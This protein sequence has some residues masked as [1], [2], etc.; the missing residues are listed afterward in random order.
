MTSS[1]LS[2]LKALLLDADIRREDAELESLL[3][4]A[5]AAPDDARDRWT[6][7]LAPSADP[8]LRDRLVSAG[9]RFMDGLGDS[10]TDGPAPAS[11]LEALRDEMRRQGLDGLVIPRTDEYQ[12]EYIPQKSER[13]LWLTG[14]SGSAGTVVVGLDKAAIFVDG[15]YT[16]Q[17]RDQVN[18]DL[19]EPRH[20]IEQP[21]TEW[22]A[23][24]FKTGDRIGFD[25]WLHT[26]HGAGH[27][28]IAAQKAGATLIRVESNPV[29]VVWTDRPAAP[30]APVVPQEMRFAGESGEDKRARLGKALADK[31]IDAAAI[32][33]TDSIAWLLNMRG[34]DVPNCPLPLSFALLNA[35]A[36]VDWFIDD[37]KLT[38]DARAALGNGIAVRPESEF[39]DALADLG[40]QGKTV[41]ADPA[42]APCLVF[43]RLSQY[44]AKTV[45]AADPC[46]LPKACKNDV[47]IDGTRVA[48]KRD[49]AALSRFLH[50]LSVEAPKGGQT[51]LSVIDRLAQFRA[52]GEHF[53][54]FSFD[55]IA[56][57][58]PNGAVI[59]YRA[60]ER[61]NRKVETGQLLLVDSGG[62]YLDGTTDVT[63][64]MAVGTPTR[65][66]MERF[67]LVLKGHIAIATARF[68][69]GVTGSQ[70]DTLAR[71]PLWQ[72]GLDFDHGTGHGVGSYLN[73]HE[74]PQRIAKA[75][76]A[77]ALKPG[78]ILSNEPGYY[79]AGEYGIRIENL[80][81]VRAV[82]TA[83]DGAE[84]DLLEFETITLAPI[85][86]TLIAVD[87]LTGSERDWLN[88][89]HA[90]VRDAVLPQL[91]GEAADWL[92][93][94]TEPV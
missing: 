61:T 76:N 71:L 40:R 39:A 7:L 30:V 11:R 94:A 44:G 20:L 79:K 92:R 69:V 29:D 24:N 27:L 8:G 32:T 3:R 12:G 78:M 34:A 22:I 55:T 73:V 36:T 85:D 42:T 89:Y 43:D 83:P 45:E 88:V 50:W 28:N 82:E 87:M 18:V 15:R 56:G 4:G 66:M 21:A 58:G 14:F 65:E 41:Q 47:E 17:V 35:D 19:F 46:L 59:H 67:T 91:D 33:A 37:R 80:V 2:D 52:E 23:E 13:V 53:R 48:H 84:K 6:E 86:R 1:A 81:V 77:V 75:F 74:G 93:Q 64:T 5:A 54:G 26:Q 51:E 90:R 72:A 49:G 25:P 16:L 63:R 68:P 10:F 57:A 70:L 38:P 31:G 62:Q 9:R 60:V